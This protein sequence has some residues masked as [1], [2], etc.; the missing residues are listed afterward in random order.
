MRACMQSTEQRPA[1]KWRVRASVAAGAGRVLRLCPARIAAAG[2]S[3]LLGSRACAGAS[4]VAASAARAGLALLRLL[5]LALAGQ[6]NIILWYAS[7][8]QQQAHSYLPS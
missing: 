1:S 8:H 7:M 5:R 2:P 3:S 6:Y 4:A